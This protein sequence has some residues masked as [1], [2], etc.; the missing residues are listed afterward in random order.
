MEAWF[1]SAFPSVDILHLCKYCLRCFCSLTTIKLHAVS[2]FQPPT[3]II[4][5]NTQKLCPWRHPPGKEIYRDGTIS[6]F[7][8]DG[9]QHQVSI[10]LDIVWISLCGVVL[11]SKSMPSG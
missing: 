4:I 5:M 8:V 7:E 9:E 11:L 10:L 3:V 1:V 6:I 2:I